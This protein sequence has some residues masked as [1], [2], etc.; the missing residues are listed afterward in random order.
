[1]TDKDKLIAAKEKWARDKRGLVPA[2]A[3][4][5]RLPPGQRETSESHSSQSVAFGPAWG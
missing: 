5:P 3:S 1:M 4:K 2:P